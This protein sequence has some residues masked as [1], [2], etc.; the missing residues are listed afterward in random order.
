MDKH[1]RPY[2]CT[3]NGC[4]MARGFA[5]KG[6]LGR[7][8]RTVHKLF[9]GPA[10]MLFCDEQDCPRG[11][12]SGTAGFSRK[13]NL[14]DH[15]RRKHRQTSTVSASGIRSV[16]NAN[17][18]VPTDVDLES[19]Q[20]MGV[21]LAASP[22]RKRRQISAMGISSQGEDLGDE[23]EINLRQELKRMRQVERDMRNE[24]TK[25]KRREEE[26]IQELNEAQHTL[27]PGMDI[28]VNHELNTM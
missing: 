9:G 24:L 12:G 7:H 22:Q 17:T 26:L 27:F 11:P 21:E 6:E 2:R 19:P 28:F 4:D 16:G 14:A 23:E 8:N 3:I 25:M 10:D 1:E 15:M 18:I 5:S 13:D 20:R